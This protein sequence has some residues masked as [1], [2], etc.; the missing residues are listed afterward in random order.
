[1]QQMYNFLFDGMELNTIFAEQTL[2]L[3]NYGR[4]QFLPNQNRVDV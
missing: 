4:I 1:M 3:I 2:K